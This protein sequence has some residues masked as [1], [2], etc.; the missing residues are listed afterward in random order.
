VFLRGCLVA[1]TFFQFR[2]RLDFPRPE[3]SFCLGPID[4]LHVFVGGQVWRG[5]LEFWRHR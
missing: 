1:E 5:D 2:G 3:F 4:F